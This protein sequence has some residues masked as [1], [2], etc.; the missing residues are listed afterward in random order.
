MA[1]IPQ[2]IIRVK[3]QAAYTLFEV[4]L[5]LALMLVLMTLIG[6][7]L[8]THLHSQFHDR[9]QVEEAQL[10]RAIL[11][12]IAE[13]LRAIV[14]DPE[15]DE[16]AETSEESEISDEMSSGT[17]SDTDST[18][19][20]E[21]AYGDYYDY[22][23]EII[24]T[25]KGLY[26]GIDWIQ[27]DTMR[28]IPGERF[29]HNADDYSYSINED[30]MEYLPELDMLNCG[31]KTVLYYLGYDSGTTDADEEY[32]Q[33]QKKT[34]VE[35]KRYQ[36]NWT[37]TDIRY[38]LYYREMNRSITQYA[39]EMGLDVATAMSDYDEHLAP[40]VERI[41]FYYYVNDDPD[42]AIE[43]LEKYEEWN[44]DIEGELPMAVEIRL[45][46]RRKTY[47]PTLL[48]GLLSSEDERER[49]V[50]YSLIVPFSR[51]MIDL[52]EV[53]TTETETETTTES[54]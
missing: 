8:N 49:T 27:I 31:Q 35:P 54:L 41:E 17:S 25:K 46:L 33:S 15:T 44:M 32:L 39:I 30:D 7:A 3:K 1:I 42:K 22:E 38:G 10:A 34:T 48:G 5:S 37:T 11:N 16:E 13:D 23:N 29:A 50:V 47:K 9:L 45:Y 6:T 18:T 26:G 52:S 36:E 19:D 24:G 2:T 12:R 43:E 14:L 4:L 51:E 53:G 40:E 20:E 28:T 21:S